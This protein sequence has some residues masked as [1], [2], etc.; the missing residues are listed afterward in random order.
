MDINLSFQKKKVFLSESLVPWEHE[1]YSKKKILTSTIS[2]RKEPIQSLF[3]AKLITDV[4]INK[5]S[6]KKGIKF[7]VESLFGILFE[8]GNIDI[9]REDANNMTEDNSLIDEQ[10][11]ET[12]IN[13]FKKYPRTPLNVVKG[14]RI[15]KDL[16]SIMNSYLTKV[17]KQNFEYTDMKF[18]DSNS[19]IIKIYSVKSKMI[20]LYILFFI[21]MYLLSLFIY[22]KGFKNFLDSIKN[23]FS[24]D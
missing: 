13:F 2:G 8:L 15:N 9:F 10:N 7:V 21:L 17:Q 5:K 3:D 12:L 19:G 4:E 24:E 20:D 1:Q 11:I 16:Y 18:Y 14:S 6:L 22:V 23:T